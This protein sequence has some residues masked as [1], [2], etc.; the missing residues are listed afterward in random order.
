[1]K[2][3]LSKKSKSYLRIKK[4]LAD[5]PTA[6][7][8]IP[9]LQTAAGTFQTNLDLVQGMEVP[10]VDATIP[11]TNYKNNKFEEFGENM[12]PICNGL[13][14]YARDTGNMVLSGKVPVVI[15]NLM[16]GD[17]MTQVQRFKSIVNAAK[18]ITPAE[19]VPYGIT[20]ADLTA[21]EDDIAVLESLIDGPR[22]AVDDRMVKRDVQEKAFGQMDDFL[23][24]TFDLAVRTRKIAFPDFVSA[25]FLARKLH[26]GPGPDN[27]PDDGEGLQPKE[28]A[29]MPSNKDLQDAL[30]PFVD[31]P[32]MNGVH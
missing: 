22:S 3:T 28:V 26:D 29:D 31:Q 11:G 10:E 5:Y 20:A 13:K 9:I 32:T 1:M 12:L 17:Q 21:L 15:T 6:V 24:E 2:E 14:L 30:T 16:E 27:T 19:L 25:Y 18:A 8:S 4:V 7:S 23:N